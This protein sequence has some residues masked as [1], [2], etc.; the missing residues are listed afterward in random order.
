MGQLNV[1]MVS[2][3]APPVGGITNWTA[4]VERSLRARNDINSLHVI[5]TSPGEKGADRTNSFSR[6]V[7]GFWSI[8]KTNFEARSLI[9]RQN[10]SVAHICTSGKMSFF[11]DITLARLFKAHGVPVYLHCHFGRIPEIIQGNSLEKKLLQTLTRYVDAFV[12]MDYETKQ[13]LSEWLKNPRDVLYLPNPI[14]VD[15]VKPI[16]P[17]RNEVVFIGHVVREKGIEEL[18]EAWKILVQEGYEW[19]LRIIGPCRGDYRFGLTEEMMDMAL[20]VEGEVSHEKAL[21]LCDRA[22]ILVLP[23]YSEGFPNCILEAM[24][25]KTS[26]VATS[27]GAIPEMLSGDCGIEVRPRDSESLVRGLKSLMDDS[28]RMYEI[29]EH[30][31]LKVC[32]EYSLETVTNCLVALWQR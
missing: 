10:I 21:E 26:V 8:V 13:A 31:Y 4:L 27:V 18:L 9:N 17:K 25:L 19:T 28:G 7:D 24:A 16:H 29:A 30:A 2:P 3:K 14:D 12:C 11:R 1:C 32:S 23:S 5:N 22:K 6:V 20:I 15:L